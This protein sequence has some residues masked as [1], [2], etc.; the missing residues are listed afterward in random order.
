M[1]S[2]YR[3]LCL[4]VQEIIWLGYIRRELGFPDKTPTI[5]IDNQ[6]AKRFAEDNIFNKRTRH[7][8]AKYFFV[9]NLVMSKKLILVWV[10]SDQQ[11]ADQ[12]TKGLQRVKVERQRNLIGMMS[13]AQF[14]NEY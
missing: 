4:A 3:A 8:A 13:L 7:I 10:E 14:L 6:S 2:E 11:A 9:R 12:F 1:E 5:Y